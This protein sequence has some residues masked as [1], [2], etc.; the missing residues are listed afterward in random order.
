M[1]VIKLSRP[2]R[3]ED[4]RC[5]GSTESPLQP[6]VSVP[7]QAEGEVLRVGVETRLL[8]RAASLLTERT[9]SWWPRASVFWKL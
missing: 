4:Q 3:F 5:G 2:L 9:Y 7:G 1:A 6:K 8:W